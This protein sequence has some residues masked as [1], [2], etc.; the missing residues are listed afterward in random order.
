MRLS[1]FGALALALTL[2]TAANAADLIQNGNFT[3][4]T[5]LAPYLGGF[6]GSEVD[7]AF[8]NTGGAVDH[9][10]SGNGAGDNVTYNIWFKGDGTEKGVN[11]G[12][13]A[14]SRW[15]EAGQRPNANYTGACN[16]AG[17]GGAFMILDGDPVAQGPFSQV[18]N[19]LV[20]GTTYSLTFDWAAG[21]LQ[22][23][24]GFATEQLHVF[25]D[26][27][28]QSTSIYHNTASPITNPGSFSGWQQVT[29]LFTATTTSQTLEVPLRRLAV[30]Q[31]AAG[32]L[33]GRRVAE[34]PDHHP[35]RDAGTG[36]LG[37]DAVG[38]WR[39]GRH[40]P[41]PARAGRRLTRGPSPPDRKGAR[42]RRG[43]LSFWPSPQAC[44]PFPSRHDRAMNFA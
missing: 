24:Q 16:L 30:E 44:N 27:A 17:C 41:P 28:E 1:A 13:D 11:T 39:S 43:A 33:P 40:A 15:G 21:E 4:T 8:H 10:T 12:T 38:L 3:D 42:L 9:W 29:M 26:A 7:P 2:G 6:S 31:P 5:G 25:L 22:D 19:G 14:K 23:R 20:A 35:H 18:V 37:D 32:G 34:S 36:H